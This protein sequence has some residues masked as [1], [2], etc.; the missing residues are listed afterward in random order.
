MIHDTVRV[1]ERE[2]C[3]P[4]T[5]GH[6]MLAYLPMHGFDGSPRHDHLD[7]DFLPHLGSESR[8][9]KTVSISRTTS[10]NRP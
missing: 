4:S 3:D 7:G 9:P 6:L 2:R 10:P 1:G 5:F 8:Q